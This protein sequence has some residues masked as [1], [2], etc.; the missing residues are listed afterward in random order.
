MS[1]IRTTSEKL[2]KGIG[3]QWIYRCN[4]HGVVPLAAEP[5]TRHD[6]TCP[7]CDAEKEAKRA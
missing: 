2:V 3:G 4:V 1:D 7:A 5:A 6:F